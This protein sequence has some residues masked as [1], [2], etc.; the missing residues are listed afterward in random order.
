MNN[1]YKYK[2]LIRWVSG[3]KA[4]IKWTTISHHRTKEGAERQA[5]WEQKNGGDAVEVRIVEM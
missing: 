2:V 5:R 1:P 3:R 4:S